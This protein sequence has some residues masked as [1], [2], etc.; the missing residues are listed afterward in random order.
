MHRQTDPAPVVPHLFS[1]QPLILIGFMG[2]GKTTLGRSMARRLQLRFVDLDQAVFE[3]TGVQ[4][5]QLFRRIGEAGFRKVE[6][7]TLLKWR[8]KHPFDLLACGGGTPCY[9]DNMELLKQMGLVVYLKIS[10][11]ELYRRL[12]NQADRRPVLAGELPEKLEEKIRQLL[13]QR[14][15]VYHQAHRI[16][17]SDFLTA[18]HLLRN[19]DYRPGPVSDCANR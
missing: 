14:S 5:D 15:P 3:E 9:A 8:A 10:P 17:E 16:V 1:T 4:P 19:L 7:A 12:Q 11:N 13:E 6:R 18:D 2:C